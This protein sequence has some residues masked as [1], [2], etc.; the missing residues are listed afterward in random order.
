MSIKQKFLIWVLTDDRAGNVAQA[1][2]VAEALQRPFITKDIRY[3]PL[4]RL[5]NILTGASLLGLTPES[6]MKL[7][8]PWPDIVISAGRRAA[9]IVRWIK[10]NAGKRVILV[11]LMN[12]GR[13]G[14]DEFDLIAM[15]R[16]DCVIPTGDAPNVM[17]T[18]GAAHRLN[19]ARLASAADSWASRIA[20]IPR[21]FIA[22]M[23]GGATHRKPFSP[24]LAADLGRRVRRMASEVGGSVLLATSRRTGLAAEQALMDTIPEPRRVFL[25][26]QG[27][28]NPYFGY[29][30]LADAIVV[31]GD[32]VS[33]CT[34]ACATPGPVYIYAPE[35]VV[36]PKHARLHKELYD[37]GL[38]RPLN[39]AVRFED[40]RHEALNPA[41]EVACAVDDL[42]YKHFK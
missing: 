32:S 38:A 28:D 24:D 29:L 34:E 25:W 3:T 7:T 31:T 6:R 13:R 16:H 4:A 40:W 12:P 14:A 26:S 30:A 23:V 27:G 9:P 11:Q 37:F 17:R 8:P 19:A 21:P 15:P 1:M 5:P 35:G 41:G 36:A 33:M 10:R 2:G 39:D 20:G 22:I 42:I 18:T